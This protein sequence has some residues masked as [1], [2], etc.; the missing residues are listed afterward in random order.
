MLAQLPPLGFPGS[1]TIFLLSPISSER[2]CSNR[3][4]REE[5]GRAG[6]GSTE[7]AYV[8]SVSVGVEGQIGDRVALAIW[9]VLSA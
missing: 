3:G 1:L 8:G 2:N 9:R 7:R 5:A 4:E 6:D